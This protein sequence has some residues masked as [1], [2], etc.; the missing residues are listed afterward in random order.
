MSQPSLIRC[1]LAE[2]RDRASLYF[3]NKGF[4]VSIRGVASQFKG[5]DGGQEISVPALGCSSQFARNSVLLLHGTCLLCLS[6]PMGMTWTLSKGP[7]SEWAL[8]PNQRSVI[9]SP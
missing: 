5:A 9:H 1:I 4:G 7:S 2:G 8:V 3:E 6:A